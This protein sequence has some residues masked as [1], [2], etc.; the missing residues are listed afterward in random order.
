MGSIFSSKYKIEYEDIPPSVQKE[1]QV[2]NEP[3]PFID[4]R[5]IAPWICSCCKV[6]YPQKISI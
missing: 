4:K 6:F 3:N 2:W 1:E 5:P